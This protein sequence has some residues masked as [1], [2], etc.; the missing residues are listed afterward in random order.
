MFFT[1]IYSAPWHPQLLVKWIWM[2]PGQY[3]QCTSPP[4]QG[5]GCWKHVGTMA[6]LAGLGVLGSSTATY[7]MAFKGKALHHH[8]LASKHTTTVDTPISLAKW[9]TTT[10]QRRSQ[11]MSCCKNI[12]EHLLL[13]DL[14]AEHFGQDSVNYSLYI[15][16]FYIQNM[17]ILSPTDSSPIKTMVC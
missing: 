10:L 1:K 8:V 3:F 15:Y 9:G 12:S 5:V 2:L 6:V 16:I 17:E 13:F 14:D 11:N 4:H 7:I